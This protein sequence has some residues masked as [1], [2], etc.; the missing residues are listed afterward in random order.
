MSTLAP[1]VHT[2]YQLGLLHFVHVL[3][4]ADGIIHQREQVVLEEIKREENISSDLFEE[5]RYSIMGKNEL[6]LFREGVELLNSVSDQDR[7]CA[8]VHLYRLSEADENIH[9]EEV[10][11]LF[12]SLKQTKVDF[13]DVV[14]ASRLAKSNKG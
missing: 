4:A 11:F 3:M 9:E 6:Q 12:N 2:A 14:L 10:R 7:L 1:P 8:L 5:F 13:E